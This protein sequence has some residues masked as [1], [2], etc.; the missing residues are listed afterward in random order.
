MSAMFV[1]GR[2]AVRGSD[3]TGRGRSRNQAFEFTAHLPTQ[4]EHLSVWQRFGAEG[5][6]G[7]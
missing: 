2:T 1:P 4:V 6:V 5:F 3:E 7:C